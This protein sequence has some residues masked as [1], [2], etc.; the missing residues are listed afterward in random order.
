M[1]SVG[2]LLDRGTDKQ[3]RDD[4]HRNDHETSDGKP[5]QRW[6]PGDTDKSRRINWLSQ[7]R[8]FIVHIDAVVSVG[9]FF[10]AE[11]I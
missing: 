1:D 4:K 9:I 6:K 11:I 3:L 5:Q 10:L 7:N 2:R 8:K